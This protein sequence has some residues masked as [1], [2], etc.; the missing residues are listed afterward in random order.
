MITPR[1]KKT[2]PTR[3]RVVYAIQRSKSPGSQVS[4]DA[5]P[6]KRRGQ[7][8]VEADPGWQRSCGRGR[9]TGSETRRTCSPPL[10]RNE[11]VA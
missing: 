5:R 3:S 9:R 7:P 8:L 11:A 4:D 6:G 1:N 2:R 10:T